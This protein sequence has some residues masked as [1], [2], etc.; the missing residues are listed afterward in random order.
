MKNENIDKEIEMCVDLL[1]K[2]Q[3]NLEDCKKDYAFLKKQEDEY[4][5]TE[6]HQKAVSAF[7]ERAEGVQVTINVLNSRLKKLKEVK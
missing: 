3:E 4:G 5:L 6:E 7:M 2:F 1:N